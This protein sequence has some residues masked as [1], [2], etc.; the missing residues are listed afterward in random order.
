MIFKTGKDFSDALIQLYETTATVTR[1]PHRQINFKSKHFEYI[2]DKLNT[3]L[4]N[5]NINDKITYE[6]FPV[7]YKNKNLPDSMWQFSSA[8]KSWLSIDTIRREL[9]DFLMADP[10][11][12]S[13][14][15]QGVIRILPSTFTIYPAKLKDN[16]WTSDD[17]ENY[18]KDDEELNS[19][20][21]ELET[22]MF[23]RNNDKRTSDKRIK[24]FA[25]AN[26]YEKALPNLDLKNISNLKLTHSSELFSLDPEYG[27][28]FTGD[29]VKPNQNIEGKAYFDSKWTYYSPTFNGCIAF[30]NHFKSLVS[31]GKLG[32]LHSNT[33][34]ILYLNK[35]TGDLFCINNNNYADNWL[36]GNFP[37]F[38]VSQE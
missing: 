35:A 16:T 32:S 27:A 34:Y 10:L 20:M 30:G 33:D 12:K 2:L 17:L 28:D 13:Y 11:T 21:K 29:I 18:G 19:R 24:D 37:Q 4:L 15:E 8:D 9:Q 23:K 36:V 3:F 25:Y 38:K 1:N 5:N 7:K 26:N 6:D 14:I 31:S 22:R